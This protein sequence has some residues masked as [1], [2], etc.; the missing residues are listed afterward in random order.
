MS[1]EHKGLPNE[2]RKQDY[3][4]F[5]YETNKLIENFT[6]PYMPVEAE[7]NQLDDGQ[8]SRDIKIVNSD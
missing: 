3:Q 1:V 8:A 2:P 5:K 4:V 6:Y 7:E